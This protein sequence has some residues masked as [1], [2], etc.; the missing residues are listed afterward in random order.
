MMAQNFTRSDKYR[1]L[2][3]V[4]LLVAIIAGGMVILTKSGRSQPVEISLSPPP[5]LRGEI[6]VGG[7]VNNPGFYPFQDYDRLGDIIRATGGTTDSPVQLKLYADRAGP[8]TPQKVN[9]NR[10]D[11]W[12]LQAL[13]GVGETR[14]KAILDYRS[15]NGPFRNNHELLKVEGFGTATYERIK[16]LI[17]VAD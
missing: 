11:A 5:E 12:L 17:T 4:V 13:P 8:E 7:A 2:I 9:L 1:I 10:A 3:A 6:Y 16:D 15:R 14:A